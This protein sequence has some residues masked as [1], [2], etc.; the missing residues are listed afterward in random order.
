[1]V[2]TAGFSATWT[3]PF[4]SG[5]YT[6]NAVPFPGAVID[7]DK[8]FV[9][10]DDAINGGQSKSGAAADFLGSEKRLKDVSERFVI[11]ADA[12]VEDAQEDV[13]SRQSVR[14]STLVLC[15]DDR[16]LRFDNQPPA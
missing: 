6:R 3:G 8:A 5:K 12:G 10:F 7:I 14:M 15:G 2:K 13:I 11:H 4:P 1:M 16:V 9:L